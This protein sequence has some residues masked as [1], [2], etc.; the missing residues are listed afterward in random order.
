MGVIF[1]GEV[2][3]IE[4]HAVFPH[5]D[6]DSCLTEQFIAMLQFLI[7]GLMCF[8]S[9]FMIFLILIQRGKGGGLAGAFGGMGGQS[10]FGT[11]AG[12]AFTRITVVTAAIWFVLCVATILS[13]KHTGSSLQGLGGADSTTTSTTDTTGTGT[14]SST[15]TS[16][17]TP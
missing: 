17:P 6:S 1:S 15:T 10:A 8:V 11:K 7:V 9:V 13:L 12:D 4:K 16:T 3:D 2:F 14:G 5:L